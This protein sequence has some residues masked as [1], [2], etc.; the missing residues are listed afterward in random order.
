VPSV[1]GAVAGARDAVVDGETG[2]LVDPTD[3]V[4]VAD[5]LTQLLSDPSRRRAL[6]RAAAERARQHAW[7]IVTGKVEQI[8]VK[9]A[10]RR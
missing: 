7:P 6:G 8:L 4:A 3:H 10:E 2:V 5:A 1:A 9:V